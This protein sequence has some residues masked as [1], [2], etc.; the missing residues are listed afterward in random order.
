MDEK[1]LEIPD[2]E[3]SGGDT[4][5]PSVPSTAPSP[6]QVKDSGYGTSERNFDTGLKAWLQ[7]L[8]AYFLWFNSW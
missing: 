1:M 8:G 5:L 2:E 3:K 7:V 6:P 4:S